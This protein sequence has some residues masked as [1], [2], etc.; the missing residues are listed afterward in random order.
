MT[1][2]KNNFN[3][4]KPHKQSFNSK[5]IT[6]NWEW[7]LA[8]FPKLILSSYKVSYKDFYFWTTLLQNSLIDLKI[9]KLK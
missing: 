5:T 7:I 8:R 3:T 9:K 2:N 6:E 1:K 4:E